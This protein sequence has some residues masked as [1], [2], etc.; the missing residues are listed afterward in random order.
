[1]WHQVNSTLG[2]GAADAVLREVAQRLGS[3]VRKADTLARVGADEFAIV[4]CDLKD[5]ADG[6]RVADK[7]QQALAAEF[8]LGNRRLQLRAIIGMSLYPTDGTDGEA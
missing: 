3:C 1:D 2:Q 6:R 8:H 4:V 5:E 7:L